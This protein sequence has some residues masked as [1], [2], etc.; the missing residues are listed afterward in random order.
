MKQRKNNQKYTN[1]QFLHVLVAGCE[2]RRWS[3]QFD[4]M[5]RPFRWGQIKFDIT[6]FYDLLAEIKVAW[7]HGF[8]TAEVGYG[9]LV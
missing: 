3:A 5:I 1:T 4:G 9:V 6:F 8:V 7:V 2:G